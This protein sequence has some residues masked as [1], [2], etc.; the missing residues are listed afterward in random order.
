MQYAGVAL[1][2]GTQTSV[3]SQTLAAKWW[4]QAFE[5][6]NS[7]IHTER[8]QSFL[9]YFTEESRL[10]K[11]WAANT[12]KAFWWVTFV[13]KYSPSSNR[14]DVLVKKKKKPQTFFRVLLG[15]ILGNSCTLSVAA[16]YLVTHADTDTPWQADC[17]R[18]LD[19]AFPLGGLS[20]YNGVDAAVG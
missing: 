6:A 13:E 19:V 5:W 10:C 1:T 20:V 7:W 15:A 16:L 8:A 17:K 2:L 3:V 18:R 4:A 12:K 11:Y 14:I 9:P